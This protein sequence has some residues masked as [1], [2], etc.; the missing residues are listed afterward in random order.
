MPAYNEH[1][2]AYVMKSQND[3]FL[4]IRDD[5]PGVDEKWFIEQFMRSHIR[6]MLDIGNPKYVNMPSPEMLLRFLDNE[7]A[8]EYRRGSEWGGFLPGWAGKVYSLYQ[9]KYDTPSRELIDSL[10]LSEI[11]RVF[12][13]LHQAGWE[14][15]VDKIHSEVLSAQNCNF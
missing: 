15:A 8:G 9:W 6:A 3:L 14:A 13:A 5:L 10:P 7:C 12:P 1:Y 11:E 4:N 2:L